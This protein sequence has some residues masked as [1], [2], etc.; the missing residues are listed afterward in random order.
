MIKAARQE[1]CSRCG[2]VGQAV[3]RINRRRDGTISSVVYDLKVICKP[4]KG[5]GL[6]CMEVRR[7]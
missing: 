5:S 1:P 2:G 6:A 7:D 3:K 4:C